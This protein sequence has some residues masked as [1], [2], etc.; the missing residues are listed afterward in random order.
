MLILLHCSMPMVAMVSLHA[1][2]LFNIQ[3]KNVEI[4]KHFEYEILMNIACIV[5]VLLL[6]RIHG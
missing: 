2:S 4:S 5:K 6:S 3:Q 1:A